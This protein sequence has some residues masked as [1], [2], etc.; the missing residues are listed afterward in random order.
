M[1]RVLRKNCIGAFLMMLF[2]MILSMS[3]FAATSVDVEIP[4]KV[5]REK[6]DAFSEKL[7]TLSVNMTPCDGAPAFD[8]S[9]ITVKTQNDETVKVSFTK[10]FTE[11]GDY[12]YEIRQ[13]KG[14]IE[15]YV[16]D[17]TVYY[18][19]VSVRYDEKYDLISSV[20]AYKDV[21][22]DKTAKQDIRFDNYTC[23]SDPPVKKV[24]INDEGNA[25]DDVFF[26]FSMKADDKSYPMPEGSVDGV[27]TIMTGVGEYEFGNMYYTE[28]GTYT[29]KV[30]E[31]NNGLPYFTY[32]G[33][34]YSVKVVVE[35]KDG[36]LIATRTI[37]NG[38]YVADLINFKNHYND[39][40]GKSNGSGGGAK[41]SDTD[42]EPHDDPA[43]RVLGAV[44]DTLDKSPAGRVLGVIR[45]ELEDGPAGRFLGALRGEVRTGDNSFMM[46][47]ALCFM[48]ALA[49]L[50]GWVKAYISRKK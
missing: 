37:Y 20:L 49:V 8:Q 50:A 36:R 5:T 45:D 34:M 43:G 48:A 33:T 6:D 46:V 29:Y 40:S 26:C 31:E 41:G 15:Q 22:G 9:S 24:V 10:T 4:V 13:S 23:F 32:D 42:G 39:G 30:V 21:Y 16:Y 17:D 1:S 14:D 7:L 28:E 11:P 25:P 19:V 38:E 12:K 35:K 44:I 27:K 47:S 18:A 3:A 2:A